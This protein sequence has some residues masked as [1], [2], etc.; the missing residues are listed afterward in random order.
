[1]IKLILAFFFACFATLGF[2]IIFHV[3]YRH[4]PVAS[5]IGA[6]AWVVYKACTL[7]E[8]S[9]IVACFT[10]SCA[11]GLL[12]DIAARLCKDA[13]TVFIIP[14]I[15]CLVPGSGMYNT[16]LSLVTG[17]LYEA[18]SIGSNTVMMAGAIALGLLV[19]GAIVRITVS[20]AQ[21]A[22]DLAGKL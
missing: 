8:I 16:M 4:I 19:I 11:V 17:D 1:M 2:C 15:L 21:R 12:S 10:A 22:I 9:P 20:I 18:A 7:Q 3:P 13:A 14:G 6:L 5:V